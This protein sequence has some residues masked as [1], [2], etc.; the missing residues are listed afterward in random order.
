MVLAI[1]SL[2]FVAFAASARDSVVNIGRALG[3]RGCRPPVL[4]AA[5][6]A[7]APASGC[8][9]RPRSWALAPVIYLACSLLP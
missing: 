9:N 5:V 4:F 3:A 7:S 2:Y 8:H 1:A 6:G